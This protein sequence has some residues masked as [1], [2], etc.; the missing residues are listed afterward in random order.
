M[1]LHGQF[2]FLQHAQAFD[3]VRWDKHM[4]QFSVGLGVSVAVVVV[5]QVVWTEVAFEGGK[6]RVVCS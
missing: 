4:V 2:P 1:S 3:M 6:A 5:C